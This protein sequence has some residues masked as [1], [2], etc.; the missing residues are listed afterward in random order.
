VLLDCFAPRRRAGLPRLASRDEAE[1][2][3]PGWEITDVEMA[4]TKPDAL[5]RLMKF[6]ERFYRLRRN[7]S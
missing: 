7:G 2:A 1:R 5:A 6:D 3:F 4:D